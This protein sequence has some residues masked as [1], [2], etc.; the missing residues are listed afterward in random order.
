MALPPFFITSYAALEAYG[1]EVAMIPLDGFK[2][3]AWIEPI[4]NIKKKRRK[5][6]LLAS[7]Q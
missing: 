2:F 1:L 6:D 7:P 5:K 4:E 3:S